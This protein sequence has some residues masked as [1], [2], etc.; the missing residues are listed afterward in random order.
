[1]TGEDVQWDVADRVATVTLDRPPVNALRTQTYQELAQALDGIASDASVSV[2]VLRSSSD[3]IFSAGAD[4]KELP[5]PPDVD[6]ARQRLSRGVFER[7]LR[8][9]VPVICA[10]PGPALGGGC[11][12]AAVCDMRLATGSAAFGLPEINVGRAGGGRFFMRLVPQGVVRHAYFT[13][14]PIYAEDAFRLGL[15]VSVHPDAPA[16][17]VAVQELA[18]EIASKSPTAIRLAK[19]SLDLAEE[20]PSLKGYE[21]EQQFSLRLSGTAD[22]RE[23][24]DAFREKRAPV[25]GKNA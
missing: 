21:A 11:A 7:I 1:L 19:Q 3:R 5:M 10:V 16:L 9:P 23:A 22:A 4:V 18:A 15:V 17:D 24:A 2:V 14:R 8:F 12:L 13:G 6:E 25:W 20:L